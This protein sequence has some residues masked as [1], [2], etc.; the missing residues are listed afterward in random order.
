[1]TVPVWYQEAWQQLL[2]AQAQGRLPHA[3]LLDGPAGWGKRFLARQLARQLTGL[4]LKPL[5]AMGRADPEADADLLTHPDVR[6]VQRQAGSSGQLRAQ[7]LIEQVRALTE[8]LVRTSAGG[9]ARV[10]I[11]EL[12]EEL[13]ISAAN[14][15]LKRLEEPGDGCHLLLVSHRSALVMPTIRSRC[16]RLLLQP[17]TREQA[18]AWL[19]ERLPESQ[20]K[21]DPELVLGLTGGAPLEAWQQLDDDLPELARQVDSFIRGGPPTPLLVADRRQADRVLVLLYRALAERVRAQPD[22]RA[23]TDLQ[24]QQR[25]LAALRALRSQNNPNVQL[26]LEDLLLGWAA[27]RSRG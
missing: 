26:L 24:R 8:F 21:A 22:R 27:Q 14:A 13:N 9:S 6:I 11:L 23:R 20:V 19:A 17:G 5:A 16:Q 2:D 12:A 3:L 25:V 18:R 15:L 1:M 4:P 7:I 10:A